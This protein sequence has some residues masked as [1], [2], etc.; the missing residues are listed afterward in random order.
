MTK[1]ETEAMLTNHA[2]WID[3]LAAQSVKT[4]KRMEELSAQIAKTD[5]QIEE[6]NRTLKELGEVTDK[7]IRDLVSAIGQLIA[8]KQ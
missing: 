8:T 2:D 1:K 7:R 4:D 3:H 6:T 5:K